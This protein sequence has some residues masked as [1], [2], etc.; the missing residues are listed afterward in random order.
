[1]SYSLN[2]SACSR[3]VALASTGPHSG[4]I[5]NPRYILSRPLLFDA[6]LMHV[7]EVENVIVHYPTYFH[8]NY[9]SGNSCHVQMD[10]IELEAVSFDATNFNAFLNDVYAQQSF[11]R[12]A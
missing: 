7:C 9:M 4:L 11:Y 12:S 1:M 2:T 3:K 5:H 10:G 6:R 8:E